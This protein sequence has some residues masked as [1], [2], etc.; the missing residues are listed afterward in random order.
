MTSVVYIGTSGWSYR[1]WL[2]V[3]YPEDLK[4]EKYLEFYTSHFTCVELNSCFYHLPLKATVK[5]WVNRTPDNFKFCPKL[6]RY[7]THQQQL[8]NVEEPLWKFFDAF[9][10]MKHKIG[11]VLVQLPPGL[12]Y[13]RNLIEGFI[14]VLKEQYLSY[15]FAFEVRN[16]SW[17]N[18]EFFSLLNTNNIAFVIADSGNRYPYN[19]TLTSDFVYLRLHGREHLYAT[20]Y[21]DEELDDFAYKIRGWMNEDKEIWAFFNND[22]NGFAVKNA[23]RLKEMISIVK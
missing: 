20:D 1:H 5:G 6:S 21:S 12:H 14:H 4:S 11:P 2:G 16:K 23:A 8:V 10:E 22:Y 9:E 13:N 7:I 15:R 17:I 19:E 3:F 18:D